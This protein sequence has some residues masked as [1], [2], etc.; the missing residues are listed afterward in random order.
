[1]CNKESVNKI[2]SAAAQKAKEL[3]NEKL[4]SVILY[5]SCARGENTEES[6]I[7]I[8]LL[9]DHP[10][11]ILRTFRASVADIASELSLNNGVTVSL[12][13]FSAE[14][15]QR[16]KNAMPFL[17]NIEKEGIKVA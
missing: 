6:D 15:Y 13:P 16:Y 5:G 12:L 4:L 17:I 1:M 9:V 2:T 11:D 7:D 10:N 14:T 8:L 3:F